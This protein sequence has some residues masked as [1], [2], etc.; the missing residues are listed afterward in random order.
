MAQFNNKDQRNLEELLE[1]GWMDRLKARGAEALGSAKGLGQQIKG[2][3]QQA[4]GSALSK[5]GDWIE[6]DKLS[7]KGQEY[8]QQGQQASGEGMVSGHNAKVQYL[9]KN[10]DKRIDSFVADIK[11][12]IKKLGLDIGNIEI[13][14]GIN[15]ALGHLKKSV[16]G[17]TP[18]PLPQQ[19]GAT[20]PPLPKQSGATPPPLPQQQ[21]DVENSEIIQNPNKSKIVQNR[22]D[23]YLPGSPSEAEED[24]D[25]LFWK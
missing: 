21:M 7:R 23:K 17:A 20:P 19:S 22:L 11:N 3:F 8:S 24:L 13:V 15:A 4:G 10:I 2:G 12:D 6:S 16:S 25:K 9:Q 14:S 18:P 1:E 5:A